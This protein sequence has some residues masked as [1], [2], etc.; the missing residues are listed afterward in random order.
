MRT[1]RTSKQIAENFRK[2]FI[3]SEDYRDAKENLDIIYKLIKKGGKYKKAA[4]EALEMANGDASDYETE[5]TPLQGKNY[6]ADEKH[7]KSD[8]DLSG[9][10]DSAVEMLLDDGMG[11]AIGTNS[12]PED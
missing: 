10:L 3:L 8:L 7:L 9:Y 1:K 12:R 6:K 5:D 4:I 11:R 2:K